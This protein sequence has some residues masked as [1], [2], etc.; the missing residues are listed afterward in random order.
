MSSK[1]A[2]F[3]TRLRKAQEVLS[4][5]PQE[6]KRIAE[7]L[8]DCAH[9]VPEL[10]GE[11]LAA[12]GIARQYTG[13]REG[14]ESAYRSA[15]KVETSRLKRGH[16]LCRWAI[17]EVERHSHADAIQK[18][19]Q[20]VELINGADPPD[21]DLAQGLIARAVVFQQTENNEDAE[22]DV[23]W[24]LRLLHP[25]KDAKLHAYAIHTLSFVLLFGKRLGN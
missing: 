24:A 15:F 23:R 22:Q 4:G 13:D 16:V 19:C 7:R 10:L 2:E 20:G 25:K 14:A 6:S 9:E 21:Q 11:V 12:V 1:A 3:R 8:L 17:L 18:A 5:D